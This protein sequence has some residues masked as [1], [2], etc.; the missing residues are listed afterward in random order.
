MKKAP[1]ISN[2]DALRIRDAM[3]PGVV[4]TAYIVARHTGMRVGDVVALRPRD[5][6]QKTGEITFRARKTG[7]LQTVKV[8][9]DI[10]RLIR[11]T[12]DRKWLF[13]SPY[14]RGR[15]I[16]RWALNWQMRDKS[17]KLVVPHCSPHS[18]RKNYA[19]T[20]FARYGLPTVRD[21]LGHSHDDTTLGYALSDRLGGRRQRNRKGGKRR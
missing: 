2:R 21:R 6:K 19:V 17:A 15:H 11:Q 1:Y 20:A 13:P 14:K 18:L 9:P 7:K 16:T 10:V 5:L 3:R 12:K 8:S 4:R